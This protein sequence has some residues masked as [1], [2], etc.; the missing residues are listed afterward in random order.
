MKLIFSIILLLAT[1][2]VSANS[3]N[4]QSPKVQELFKEVLCATCAGQSIAE[5]DT[6]I[7][8]FLRKTI[9]TMLN[10]GKTS[11]QIKIYLAKSYGEQ[12]LTSPPINPYTYFLWIA[13]FVLLMIMVYFSR[14]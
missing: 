3:F 4:E 11:K 7:A 14:R 12:I 10:E 5:S 1:N 13:P 9:I 2:I 8:R 6:N